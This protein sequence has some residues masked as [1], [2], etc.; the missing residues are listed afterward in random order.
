MSNLNTQEPAFQALHRIHRTIT[1]QLLAQ[2]GIED[3]GSPLMLTTLYHHFSIQNQPS[4]RQLAQLLCVTPAT[5]AM[6]LKSMVRAGYVEKTPDLNDQRCKRIRLTQKGEEA[7]AICLKVFDITNGC[8]TQ[9]FTQEE[10]AQLDSYNQRMLSNVTTMIQ[11]LS[12]E[13]EGSPD[14]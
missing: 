7:A 1:R 10:K 2:H 14:L 13:A 5:I 11:E 3:L 6:S 8:V 12:I 9:G 4:Q